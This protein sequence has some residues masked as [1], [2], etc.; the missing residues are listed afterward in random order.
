MV[1]L[2]SLNEEIKRSKNRGVTAILWD[3]KSPYYWGTPASAGGYVFE[4]TAQTYDLKKVWVA[5]RRAVEALG[6][7]PDHRI[8]RRRHPCLPK[9][10]SYSVAEELMGQG[11]V[12]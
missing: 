10:V 6:R 11:K 9:S 2:V 3:Y 7:C 8:D 5:N 4:K 12:A 1:S